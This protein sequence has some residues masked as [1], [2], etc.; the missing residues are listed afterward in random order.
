MSSNPA[1]P[2]VMSIRMNK[3]EEGAGPLAQELRALGA[4]AKDPL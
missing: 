1:W 4:L 3:E 2:T